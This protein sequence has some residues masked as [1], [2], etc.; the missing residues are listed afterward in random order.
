VEVRKGIPARRGLDTFEFGGVARDVVVGEEEVWVGAVEEHDAHSLVTLDLGE[1][2]QQLF[3]HHRVD[4]VDRRVVEGDP[5]QR[6]RRSVQIKARVVVIRKLRL[7]AGHVTRPSRRALMM[8]HHLGLHTLG[9]NV[10]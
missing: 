6:R 1:Q 10:I 4:Q 7:L 3:H 8:E 2:V 5:P 9:S